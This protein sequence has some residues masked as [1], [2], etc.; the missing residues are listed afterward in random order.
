[1]DI[2]WLQEVDLTIVTNFDE[3]NEVAD[4]DTQMVSKGECDDIDILED[5]GDTVDIQFGNGS[6]AFNVKKE[7]FRRME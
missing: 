2:M 7:W 1:M 6:V 4:E 5:K 3:K